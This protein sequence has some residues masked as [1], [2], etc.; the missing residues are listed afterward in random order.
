[1][2]VEIMTGSK[3]VYANAPQSEVLRRIRAKLDRLRASDGG[4]SIFGAKGHRY[5][6]AP[7]LDDAHLRQLEGA[8]G[9]ALPDELRIFLK[10]VHGGGPGPGYGLLLD[11]GLPCPE[12][13]SRPFAYDNQAAADVLLRRREDRWAWLPLATG[14]ELDDEW[15]PRCGFVALSHQGCDGYSGIVVTGE[16]RGLIWICA[17]YGWIPETHGDKQLGFLDWYEMWLD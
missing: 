5:R 4:F 2:M 15:P 7:A 17:E 14:V 11:I 1:M 12:W 10:Y 3:D 16:Q 8:L 13:A 9:V 6:E